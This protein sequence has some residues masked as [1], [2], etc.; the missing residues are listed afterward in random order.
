MQDKNNYKYRESNITF[1]TTKHKE[2]KYKYLESSIE[3]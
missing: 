3:V 1:K 2:N